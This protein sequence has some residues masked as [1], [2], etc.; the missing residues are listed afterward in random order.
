MLF[1]GLVIGEKKKDRRTAETNASDYKE[2]I[3]KHFKM[4]NLPCI[5]QTPKYI[6]NQKMHFTTL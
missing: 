6:N 1:E 5:N 4:A 2:K 3:K